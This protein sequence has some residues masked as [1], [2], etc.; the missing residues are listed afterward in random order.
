MAYQLFTFI[1]NFVSLHASLIALNIFYLLPK[2]FYLRRK[3]SSIYIPRQY[4]VLLKYLDNA[5]FNV[6]IACSKTKKKC[7]LFVNIIISI[8][9]SIE[10]Y[11]NGIV[12]K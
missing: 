5:N 9:I 3:I 12:R 11:Y 8:E 10:I 7:E 1:W 6:L 2:G 4:L